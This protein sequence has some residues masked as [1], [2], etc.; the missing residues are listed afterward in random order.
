M[1][2]ND[3]SPAALKAAMT[4]GTSSWGQWGSATEHGV[5]VEPA[6]LGRRWRKCHCGCGKRATHRGAANGVTLSL[7]CELAMRR[8]ARQF[9]R[10]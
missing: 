1:P 9:Q 3:L 5:Y 4:G 10:T 7:G 2:L 8:F 6:N